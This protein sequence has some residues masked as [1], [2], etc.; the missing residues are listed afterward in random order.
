MFLGTSFFTFDYFILCLL[1]VSYP[2]GFTCRGFKLSNSPVAG[3]PPETVS[4]FSST[5]AF[6]TCSISHSEF[7]I[8]LPDVA[9]VMMMMM[10]VNLL[11]CQNF[12]PNFFFVLFRLLILLSLEISLPSFLFCF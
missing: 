5:T 9:A 8:A 7:N 4:R 12:S 11:K 1:M 3:A 2:T 10:M 6:G